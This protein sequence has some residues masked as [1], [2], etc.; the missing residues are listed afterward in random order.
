[1]SGPRVDAPAPPRAAPDSIAAAAEALLLA[2][3]AWGAFAFGAVYEWAWWPAS[4]FQHPVCRRG[5]GRSAYA[6]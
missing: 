4:V 6:A 1:M 3:I 2:A 5:H